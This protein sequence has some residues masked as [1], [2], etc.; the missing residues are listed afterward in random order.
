MLYIYRASVYIFMEHQCVYIILS[1]SVLYSDGASVIYILMEHQCVYIPI[2]NQCVYILM[3][4]QCVYIMMEHQC[5]IF[6]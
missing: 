5:F 3:K 2:E 1:S 4:Q 6:L